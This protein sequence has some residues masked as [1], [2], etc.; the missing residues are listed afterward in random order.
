VEIREELGEYEAPEVVDYGDLVE[1]TAGGNTGRCLDSDF[2]AGTF[3]GDLT[4]SSC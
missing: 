2:K 4:F 1:L 3:Y